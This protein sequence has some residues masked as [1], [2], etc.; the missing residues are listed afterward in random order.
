MM[1][2][3]NVRGM[4]PL[5]LACLKG[6]IEV[7]KVFMLK[8]CLKE[9]DMLK[10]DNDDNTA[11]HFACESGKKEIIQLLLEKGEK[12][13]IKALENVKNVKGE[14][15]IHIAA[16]GGFEDIVAFL[17]D[18]KQVDISTRDYYRRTVLHHAAEND[19]E[20]MVRFLCDR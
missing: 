7:V 6:C 10:R 17:L 5:H 2:K 16:Y 3:K 11:V 13:K 14:A 8:D 20:G 12:L 4:T 19:Q 15:P 18:E 1:K 9:D